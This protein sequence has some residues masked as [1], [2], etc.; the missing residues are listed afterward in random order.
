MIAALVILVA[1]V[2]TAFV[3]VAMVALRAALL[4]A[5]GSAMVA[6]WLVRAGFRA[7]TRRA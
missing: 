1:V 4:L 3:T 6:G 7:L 5:V 2:V